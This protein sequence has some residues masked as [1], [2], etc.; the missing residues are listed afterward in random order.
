MPHVHT[1][2]TEPEGQVTVPPTRAPGKARFMGV[3][4][5]R[6]VA[7]LS[8]LAANIFDPLTAA[9]Q[10]SL[11]VM[12]VRGRSATLFVIV[13][14]ISLAFITGGRHPVRGR[15]RQAARANIAVRA[16]LIGAIGLALGYTVS[17]DWG[18]I[19]G[20]Y[21][22]FFLLAIPLVGLRPRTLVAIAGGLVVVG[23]LLLLGTTML[24]VDSG[25][26]PDP[27]LATPFT[28][29]LGLLSQLFLT[30]DFPAVVYMA[31]ICLG[32]AIGRLDLSSTEVAARLLV[33]GVALA[34]VTWVVSW[35]L[36]FPLGGLQHLLAA[37]DPGTTPNQVVWNSDPL[38]SWW[39]LALHVDHSGTPIDMLHT[40]GSATAVIGA[41]LL[42]S[43]LR[44]A[45]RLLWPVAVAGSMTLTIYTVHV[46][47]LSYGVLENHNTAMWLL[48]TAGAL[49]FA[50][51]WHN[52][53]GQG[54]LERLVSTAAGR[55]R[56][57]V[58]AAPTRAQGGRR[59]VTTFWQA[60][61]P[62]LRSTPPR[63]PAE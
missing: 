35:L 6:G 57:A 41:V 31:Y 8:M 33:G 19:L 54:P 38:A 49:V 48:L 39:W 40:I 13:A 14:G 30:G 18:V 17:D 4:V 62:W 52:W 56:A 12:T 22:L 34:V 24:G 50:V 5:A 32:L 63:E 42:V 21:G 43:R 61:V 7:L 2:P 11:A 16:V 37:S 44:V 23:P 28:D 46:P 58:L 53:L 15:V 26:A 3:D 1:E 59:G 29:P 55:A 36:V 47:L 45:R 25:S 9:G 27:T 60:A 10:P 51:V 20:Y